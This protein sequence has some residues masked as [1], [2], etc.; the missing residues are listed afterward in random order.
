MLVN[1]FAVEKIATM[2]LKGGQ[3]SAVYDSQDGR[4]RLARSVER[5]WPVVTYTKRR[6]S[7]PQVHVKNAWKVFDTRLKPKATAPTGDGEY[8]LRLVA[9]GELT[10]EDVCSIAK[11]HGLEHGSD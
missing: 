10:G 8:G 1:V 2:T 6:F 4:L 11:E 5:V 3:T 9:R 7:K